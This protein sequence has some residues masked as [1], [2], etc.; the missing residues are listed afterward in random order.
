[1][2]SYSDDLPFGSSF[3]ASYYGLCCSCA[4]KRVN[5]I[6]LLNFFVCFDAEF[7]MT[8]MYRA[9]FLG[10]LCF[11][12]CYICDLDC[13][14]NAIISLTFVLYSAQSSVVSWILCIIIVI[15]AAD[16]LLFWSRLT[17]TLYHIIYWCLHRDMSLWVALGHCISLHASEEPHVLGIFVR[18]FALW[19]LA[20]PPF[21]NVQIKS[22]IFSRDVQ[23]TFFN[24]GS[25]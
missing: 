20:Q 6:F 14:V 17:R 25:V 9:Q 7:V 5:V 18:G 3:H 24:F 8:I 10:L 13:S 2:T 15:G 1:M 16:Q 22:G 4:V 19:P 23:N 21:A 12:M 11:I